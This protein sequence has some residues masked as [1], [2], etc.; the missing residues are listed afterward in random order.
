MHVGQQ[1]PRDPLEPVGHGLG[2]DLVLAVLDP[3]LNGDVEVGLVA[4][5]PIVFAAFIED[6][7]VEVGVPLA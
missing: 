7:A 1:A 3:L 6:E 2:Q 5:L 4:E